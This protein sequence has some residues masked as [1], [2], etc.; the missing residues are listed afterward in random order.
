MQPFA[1]QVAGQLWLAAMSHRAFVALMR[2]IGVADR[3]VPGVEL[4]AYVDLLKHGDGGRAFL[5][6]MRGFELTAQ[7]RHVYEG[8]VRDVPYP[9]Q[10]AW[11]AR[12]PA[13]RL[14][15]HGRQVVR[16]T[17]VARVYT[18][19]AEHFLPEDQAPAL[20]EYVAALAARA[21]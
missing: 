3:S 7:K 1:W 9:V 12:D 8:V 10:V 14:A 18:V 20:A 16:A 5:R 21:A 17:A 4:A 11:G 2:G 13:L 19:P 6:I 15:V